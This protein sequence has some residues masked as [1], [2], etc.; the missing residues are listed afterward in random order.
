MQ[1][2]HDEDDIEVIERESGDDCLRIILKGGKVVGGQAIGGFAD[3]IG[4]F[5]GAMWRRDDLNELR[6]TWE[7][8][9]RLDSPSPWVYRKL[10]RLIGLSTEG[11][12]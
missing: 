6:Q 2:V 5:M 12:I 11:G 4:L 3:S 7:R 10:G 8:I 1:S 9:S